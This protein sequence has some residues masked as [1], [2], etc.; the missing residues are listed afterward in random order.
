MQDAGFQ[1]KHGRPLGR[2]PGPASSIAKPS[3]VSGSHPSVERERACVLVL[4]RPSR[5]NL[6]VALEAG[7]RRSDPSSEGR[8]GAK[9][10]V[11]PQ[12]LSALSLPSLRQDAGGSVVNQTDVALCAQC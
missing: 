7:W 9:P 5:Q 2:P 12:A 8:Q 6:Q 1:H 4:M 11:S 3:R 10:A